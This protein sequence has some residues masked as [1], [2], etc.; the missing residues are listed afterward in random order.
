MRIVQEAIT[1]VVKHAGAATV[2]VRTGESP[3][4]GGAAGVFIEVADDGRGI[5]ADAPRG[6][7]LANMARRAS[8][9]GGGL[10]VRSNGRGTTVRLWIPRARPAA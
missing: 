5:A 8:R 10:D 4:A 1:N 9:I 2:T 3:G 6:R 7:G